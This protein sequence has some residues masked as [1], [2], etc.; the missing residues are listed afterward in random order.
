MSPGTNSQ[1]SRHTWYKG[2]MYHMRFFKKR[3]AEQ[4]QWYLPWPFLWLDGGGSGAKGAE[5]PQLPK[6]GT[7]RHEAKKAAT[8]KRLATPE[9]AKRRLAKE[10]AEAV[11][12]V[13]VAR[14]RRLVS[15]YTNL[16]IPSMTLYRNELQRYL[17]GGPGLQTE[18]MLS[19]S[20]W[21]GR[22]DRA[23]TQPDQN[24]YYSEV[25]CS[26]S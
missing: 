20:G 2:R 14:Y 21:Q 22:A 11:D 19:Y 18:E 13:D 1:K 25:C 16:M 15:A 10:A 7:K 9:A 6:Q 8:N 3:L 4:L 17:V 5:Q 24:L 12:D 23:G 26:E